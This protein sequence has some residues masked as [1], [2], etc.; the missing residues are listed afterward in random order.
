MAGK[1]PLALAATTLLLAGCASSASRPESTVGTAGEPLVVIVKATEFEFSDT[2]IRVALGQPVRLIMNNAGKLEHDLRIV[3]LPAQDVRMGTIAPHTHASGEPDNAAD[4]SHDL[5]P[6][7]G[8]AAGSAA[9]HGHAS[10][11]ATHAAA[12]T[13]A[14][15]E[16]TPTRKGTYDVDCTVAG[17]REAGMQG[18]LIV[19]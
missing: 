13:Q 15:V 7:T 3:K 17:H 5:V 12:G 18:K 4:H 11:V 1:A 16:F 10:E 9:G 19:E 14:W 6:S 2:P 8:G